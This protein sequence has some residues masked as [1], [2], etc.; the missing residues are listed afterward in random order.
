MKKKLACL[1]VCV[2][3][4]VD[5]ACQPRTRTKVVTVAAPE[6]PAPKVS[7][8][9]VFKTQTYGSPLSLALADAGC[10]TRSE[11]QAIRG[12]AVQGAWFGYQ[13]TEEE[14]IAITTKILDSRT[15]ER[16]L[17]NKTDMRYTVQGERQELKVC[18]PL[19]P[20]GSLEAVALQLKKAVEDSF[21]FYKKLQD[22]TPLLKLPSIPPIG[23]G[24]FPKYK[25]DVKR[26][27]ET[28]RMDGT[29]T[30]TATQTVTIQT[31]N[32][33]Y[34]PFADDTLSPELYAISVIPQSAEARQD[35]IFNGRGL[36]E[37]P[38]VIHHEYGHHIFQILFGDST[39]VSFQAYLDYWQSHRQL[40]AIHGA[41]DAQDRSGN[42][43][44]HK[45]RRAFLSSPGYIFGS[46]N[47]GFADLF[48]H[49]SMKEAK[50]LFDIDCFKQTRDVQSPVMYGGLPK[51]WDTTL[52]RETFDISVRLGADT[53]NKNES[54]PLELCS[55]PSF[56]DIHVVG[57]VL[58]H[59][60]DAVFQTTVATRAPGVT[61]ALHKAGLLMQWLQDLRASDEVLELSSK[62]T[63]S[64]IV[65]SALGT[66]LTALG[67][68]DKMEFCTVVRQKFPI[69]LSRW[70]DK[71][72]ED[73]AG[74]L[75]ACQ[76]AP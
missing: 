67:K 55:I 70:Q 1:S 63:L 20:D 71:P 24:L 31:D 42:P 9:L 39:V 49:Y 10:E 61:P 73:A 48:A 45:E 54:S 56:D 69:V 52:W 11:A 36:W 12:S 60:V 6:A 38:V 26:V 65:N 16:E 57:A 30:Q 28:I 40:H 4:L 34:S 58:A 59:T 13:D 75:E 33:F 14:T 2:L 3:A 21:A 74:I 68:H 47:E 44:I 43:E 15:F 32:A 35:G 5:V 76:S 46:L 22:V 53:V 50:G 18:A 27:E 29:K 62:Q 25:K 51:I 66:A 37:F 64:R 7:E 23:L 19:A 8:P 41:L 17:T 72:A